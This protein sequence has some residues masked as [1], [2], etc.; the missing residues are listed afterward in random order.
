MKRTMS[1]S[2]VKHKTGGAMR[3]VS[4]YATMFGEKNTT[5]K[6]EEFP[7]D[8]SFL[9]TTTGLTL[10]QGSRTIHVNAKEQQHFHEHW[11]GKTS[12][13][14]D[15]QK[16]R[17]KTGLLYIGD[18]TDKLCKLQDSPWPWT[19]LAGRWGWQSQEEARQ[20]KR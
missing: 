20:G 9:Q 6:P 2:W 13:S 1:S 14:I 10:Q 3:T 11:A 17:R 8:A 15:L 4:L 19:H 18:L 16:V 5:Y 7:I 12:V